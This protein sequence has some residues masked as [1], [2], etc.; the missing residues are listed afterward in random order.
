MGDAVLQAFLYVCWGFRFYS[1]VMEAEE[2]A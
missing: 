1:K 2:V